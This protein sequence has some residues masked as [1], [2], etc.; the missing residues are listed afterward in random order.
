M[1]LSLQNGINTYNAVSNETII[2]PAGITPTQIVLTNC[3]NV[4]IQGVAFQNYNLGVYGSS[5]AV[6]KIED[7]SNCTVRRVRINNV[8]PSPPTLANEYK[9]VFINRSP[10][11]IIECSTFEEKHNGSAAIAVNCTQNVQ[12]NVTIRKCLFRNIGP[13][14]AAQDGN[15]YESIRIGDST[16]SQESS[17]S[18]IECC[19]FINCGSDG[20]PE[21]VS[22]KRF[23]IVVQNCALY[24]CK[25]FLTSRHG[26]R[27]K[28]YNNYVNGQGVADSGGI[29]VFGTN[30]EIVGN[31][32]ANT[33]G[34]DGFRQAIVV[35][36][37]QVNPALNGYWVAN[38]AYLALNTLV[39]NKTGL[40]I[41][42]NGGDSSLSVSP[43]N[44]VNAGGVS[45]YETGAL[46]PLTEADVG[47]AGPTCESCVTATDPCATGN[48]IT[49]GDFASNNTTG[50]TWFTDGSASVSAATG[51]A[52][53]TVTSGSSN[54]QFYQNNISVVSGTQYT[55]KFRA[56]ANSA[57]NVPFELLQD[58]S[59]FNY[60]GFSQTVPLTTTPT[61]FSFTFTANATNANSRF[62]VWLSGISSRTITV[63]NVCLAPSSAAPPPTTQSGN[64]LTNGDFAN[65]ATGWSFFTNGTASFSAATG[66]AVLTVSNASSNTQ[67]YQF[68]LAVTSGI[69]YNLVFTAK[70]TATVNLL[71]MLIKH[72][73]PYTTL[74]VNQTLALTP[75]EKTFTIPFTASATE[76]NARLRFVLDGI[77]NNTITIDSIYLGVPAE[78]PE[79]PAASELIVNGDF[80]GGLT[81]WL[82][83]TNG[84]ASA[85]AATGAAG[86]SVTNGGANTQLYQSGISI[87]SGKTYILKLTARANNAVDLPVAIHQNNSP[88]ATLGLLQ[89]AALTPTARTYYMTFTAPA[90]EADARLRF[91]FDGLAAN[92]IIIDDVSLTEYVDQTGTCYI[93]IDT[94]AGTIIANFTPPY[95]EGKAPVTVQ[96]SD[97]SS[98]SHGITYREWAYAVAGTGVWTVFSTAINP[99]FTFPA[100]TYDVRL[101]AAGPNGISAFTGTVI[102]TGGKAKKKGLRLGVGLGYRVGV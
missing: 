44:V 85:S 2:Q 40:S 25:G 14:V 24:G 71:V 20:E 88:Y 47:H 57:V 96:F 77:Q 10:G 98:A 66:A 52:V 72:D 6:I 100:G 68:G 59:P 63:D 1:T 90:T 102:A 45:P 9:Y 60:L 16:L 35:G 64:L 17:N 86:V 13:L 55:V 95:A 78:N 54:T 73:S 79:P 34:N 46:R 36:N 11:T 94:V 50:W 61:D 31:Y 70:A 22:L 29:R 83:F 51:A 27:N 87:T 26:G 39:N 23:D 76:A 74:G 62:R 7:S 33:N 4:V 93:K 43:T 89:S 41:G 38:N 28:F 80:S 15:G 12:D 53:I 101:L 19:V 67:L 84:T 30:C 81:S 5:S 48:K 69:A 3:T 49:N 92:T 58:T 37:G 8:N 82:F 65:G 56:S 42:E 32:V 21:A 99:Q 97:L 18:K 91:I 75:T